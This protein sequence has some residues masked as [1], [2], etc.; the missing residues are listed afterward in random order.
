MSN[1]TWGDLLKSQADDETIEEAIARI[2]AEHNDDETSH[3]DTGQSLQS[4][5]AAEII[6]HLAQ[7]IVVDKMEQNFFNKI[8]IS[9]NFQSLDSFLKSTSGIDLGFSGVRLYTSTVLNNYT[10]IE[11][12]YLQ[13]FGAN[14]DKDPVL[15]L[16]IKVDSQGTRE[17]YFGIGDRE[18]YTDEYFAGFKVVNNTL[19]ARIYSIDHDVEELVEITG[20]TVTN[21]NKYRIDYVHGVGCYFY[22]NG[23]LKATITTNLPDGGITSHFYS[24]IKTTETL[25]QAYLY[26]GPFSY[27]EKI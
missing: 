6:D 3:L 7:S 15:D 17:A 20:I 2:I 13:N 16:F 10:F 9:G 12:D 19:Y 26:I 23:I 5:K 1:L 8:I 11:T 18:G 24:S 25:M 4:H 21:F 27:Y 22:V 14:F